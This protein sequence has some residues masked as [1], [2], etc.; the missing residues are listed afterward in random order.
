MKVQYARQVSA[1]D[2]RTAEMMPLHGEIFERSYSTRGAR[3]SLP[4]DLKSELRV[5]K[6][7]EEVAIAS[8]PK[9]VDR[10]SS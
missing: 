8:K 7:H 6:L 4:F 3:W 1:R 2:L 5:H 10:N 9:H